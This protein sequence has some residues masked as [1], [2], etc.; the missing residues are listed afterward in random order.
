MA[1]VRWSSDDFKSDVYVY[2]DVNGGITTMVAKSRYKDGPPARLEGE[3]LLEWIKKM[4]DAQVAID[5]EGAGGIYN[6]ETPE[7]CIMRLESLRAV[8][9]HV[10]EYALDLL[11]EIGPTSL[12]V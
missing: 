8:G 7:L 3:T 10:P 9:F 2:S 12:E 6:D 4:G 5:L 1:F 11:R